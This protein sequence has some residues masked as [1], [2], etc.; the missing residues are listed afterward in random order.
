M[1]RHRDR[2]ARG[3]FRRS[4][5]NKKEQDKASSGRNHNRIGRPS[6]AV[7]GDSKRVRECACGRG[8]ACA[9]MT[10]AFRLLGD[11]RC[12][13]VELPRFRE[14]PPAYKY[15]FRN[16]LRAAYVRH[17][18]K[19][20]PAFD[21]N[22]LDSDSQQSRY[23][24]LHHFHPAVVKAF[25]ANPLTSAQRHKVP[26]SITE[27]ELRDLNMD[28]SDGDRILSV[29]GAATGGYYFVPSY[30][31][32]CAHE[33]LKNLI[34][35]E[36]AARQAAKR[37]V[38]PPPEKV[39]PAQG[40]VI[41]SP[42]ETA[43]ED[44][45]AR[46]AAVLRTVRPISAAAAAP[47]PSPAHEDDTDAT[48]SQVEPNK[49]N[50][51]DT[52]ASI[53]VDDDTAVAKGDGTAVTP[54]PPQPDKRDEDED[55]DEDDTH[56][57]KPV[58]DDTAVAQD[59]DTAVAQD[60]GT[61]VTSNPP[62]PD[63]RD[64]DEDEDDT[65]PSKP[66]D[67]DAAVAK[68][69]D[70]AVAQD[71]GTAVTSNPAQPDK[72]DEDD[73]HPSK[74]VDDDTAVAQ[75]DDTA[76]AQDDHAAVPTSPVQPEKRD[77]DEDDNDEDDD[78]DDHD[79]DHDDDST[80]P[81]TTGQSNEDGEFETL[82]ADSTAAE[83]DSLWA[84]DSKDEDLE[85]TKFT[86]DAESSL[87]N[88]DKSTPVIV[89]CE[90]EDVDGSE[91]ESPVNKQ[92]SD[93]VGESDVP[94]TSANSTTPTRETDHP[95]DTPK[96]RRNTTRPE[97]SKMRSSG[98]ATFID[99]SVVSTPT[100]PSEDQKLKESEDSPP[101]SS[102]PI[103]EEA[104]TVPLSADAEKN[105]TAEKAEKETS[106]MVPVPTPDLKSNEPGV[107]S[108]DPPGASWDEPKRPITPKRP[109]SPA[110][111]VESVVSS[112]DSLGTTTSS[113]PVAL[114][115]PLP[116]TDPT[117]RI[118]VHNELIAWES[119]RRSSLA[120]SLE[121][122][123]E[124]WKA[125][126]EILRA[127]VDEVEYA[128]RL[129][130]GFAKA[131]SVFADSLQAIHDDKLLDDAGNTVSNSFMQNRLQKQRQVQEY[132]IDKSQA[133]TVGEGGSAVLN[134]LINAQL[135]LAKT[136]RDSSQHMEEEILVEVTDLRTSIQARA[137][138]IESVG[139]GIIGE[140]KRSES[141]VK[142]IWGTFPLCVVRKCYYICN[143]ANCV[144]SFGF[145]CL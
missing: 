53:P 82:V 118:Q 41:Q 27:H 96:Y 144:Y 121:F 12:Y 98:P 107:L 114:R 138:E 131:G 19:S 50:E 117:M 26:I 5:A 67:D 4:P 54:N 85:P 108:P 61:A 59:D 97:M 93:Y 47:A 111:T 58:D 15:V 116:G 36:R 24:A 112:D 124:Q 122:N 132:S 45:E 52:D 141:E 16:N 23:V 73:T 43:K 119:K 134:S 101:A 25:H 14:D 31:H 65:H 17:L 125:A 76:V 86:V 139:D 83:F 143:S 3:L 126:R 94:T 99:P 18:K 115:Q 87:S 92:Q 22:A 90:N 145:R 63:K 135:D 70:T 29:T 104:T 60:D 6:T 78:H 56:P 57:S 10:Q 74:P 68:D 127:G 64:E 109:L 120:R 91:H 89:E 7:Q 110:R 137:R 130:L 140:L 40:S 20:S 1:E 42:M 71:D 128:E 55:E 2:L 8:L 95:W 44:L 13:Y 72:R 136:M 30:P 142:N 38:S 46:R 48:Q 88:L 37:G 75:D 133:E 35:A 9:G 129:V 33:D 11:P 105:D 100:T 51:D 34:R 49:R 123:R 80:E 81:I 32:A 103:E 62:Q 106:Q 84:D 21:V 28:F 77:E 113:V 66:V 79:H 102:E 39:E 69:D